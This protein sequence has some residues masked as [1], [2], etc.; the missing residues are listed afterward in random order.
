MKGN[1]FETRRY[2]M[3]RSLGVLALLLFVDLGAGIGA[4]SDYGQTKTLC[5]YGGSREN[6]VPIDGS[7]AGASP[8]DYLAPFAMSSSDC[9]LTDTTYTGLSGISATTH[10][11]YL[12]HY[13]NGV[14]T[15]STGGLYQY[16]DSQSSRHQYQR[17]DTNYEVGGGGGIG[18]GHSQGGSWLGDGAMTYDYYVLRQRKQSLA[19]APGMGNNG[20]GGGNFGNGQGG[21]NG[22]HFDW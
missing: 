20:P 13:G 15:F 8:V 1:S 5:G 7:T 14:L 6:C 17:G 9:F 4:D 19:G 10:C 18:E 3:S 12:K 2:S 16:T 21:N 22:A 11:K